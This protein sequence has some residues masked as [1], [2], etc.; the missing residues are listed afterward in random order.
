MMRNRQKTEI[1]Y[2]DAEV[3]VKEEETSPK[4]SQGKAKKQSR[5]VNDD[6]LVRRGDILNLIDTI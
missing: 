6:W 3:K 2:S 5:R 4:E 1:D